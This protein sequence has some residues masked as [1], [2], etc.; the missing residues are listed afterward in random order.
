M[1]ALDI[2]LSAILVW[3]G[4]RGFK[5]GLILEIFSNGALVLATTGSIQLLD[6][7]VKLCTKWYDQQQALLPYVL[8]VCLFIVILMTITWAGKL[9]K[10]IIKPTLLGGL[11]GLLG[12]LLGILKWG[13]Y[14]STCLWLGDLLQLKIPEMYTENSLFFPMIRS[15][16]P[17]LLAWCSTWSPYMQQWYLHRKSINI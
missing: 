10:T 1:Q 14:S 16:V 9:L 11:D 4:Y 12:S 13:I 17:Q 2:L 7:A 5:R 3:G 8:F 6:H 15:L